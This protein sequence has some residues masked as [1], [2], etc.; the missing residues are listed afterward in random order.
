MCVVLLF[1]SHT[2]VVVSPFVSLHHPSRVFTPNT[3]LD[4]AA[5]FRGMYHDPMGFLQ[6]SVCETHSRFLGKNLTF[7]V[8]TGLSVKLWTKRLPALLWDQTR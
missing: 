1:F 4:H 2:V 5:F 6:L 7:A 3:G 8:A